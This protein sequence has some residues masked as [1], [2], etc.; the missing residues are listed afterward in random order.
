MRVERQ[1]SV[2]FMTERLERTVATDVPLRRTISLGA[3]AGRAMM[4]DGKHKIAEIIVVLCI[5][6]S[7]IGVLGRGILEQAV[8]LNRPGGRK[9]FCG[10]ILAL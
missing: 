5:L 2:G 9:R 3:A 7:W 10:A 4:R 6:S 1:L 8:K